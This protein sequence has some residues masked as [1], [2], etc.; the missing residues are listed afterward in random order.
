[1][2]IVVKGDGTR[3]QFNIQ[4]L[5]Q[6]LQRSGASTELYERIARQVER[7]IKDGMTTSEIY[8]SAFS[9]LRKEQGVFAA[10]YSMRRALL[11]MGPTGFPFEDYFAELMRAR[12]YEAQVR[13]QIQ[14]KCTIHEVDVVLKKDDRIIGAELK[15][16]NVH[17]F[18]TDLKTALYVR[19][20]FTDIET[21][22]KE[23]D[24]EPSVREAWL[25]TNTKFTV[26]AI[27]YAECA[28][29]TLLGWSHPA[30]NNLADI[31]EETKLYPITVLTEISRKEEAQLLARQVTLCRDIA[32]N[33]DVLR[34]AGIPRRKHQDIVSESM[35]LCGA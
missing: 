9:L 4:K 13:Q 6:S 19:A 25:V 22:A 26:Q 21:L 32:K 33:P 18:K 16:H 7:T 23:R 29:V 15:F 17:G 30:T 14:G 28:G 12:G 34:E 1:M 10:R 35:Q 24:E 5:E 11:D 3:E 8:R 27:E 31:I 20:R 2:S